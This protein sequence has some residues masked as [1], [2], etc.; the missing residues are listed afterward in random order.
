MSSDDMFG[1]GLC[2]ILLFVGFLTHSCQLSDH[3]KRLKVIEEKV[4]IDE[5]ADNAKGK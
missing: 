2:I 5:Q 4:G 3:G 1:V